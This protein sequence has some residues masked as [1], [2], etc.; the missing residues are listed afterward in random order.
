MGQVSGDDDHIARAEDHLLF[1]ILP[2]PKMHLAGDHLCNLLIDMGVEGN[3][4]P[5]FQED[6][7]HRHVRPGDDLTFH[8]GVHL[9]PF[10]GVPVEPIDSHC[11]GWSLQSERISVETH[12]GMTA[13]GNPTSNVYEGAIDAIVIGAGVVGLA[14]AKALAETGREVIVLERHDAFGMETSSRNSEVI[15]AGIYYRPG[16]VRARLCHPGK[17]KLFEYARRKNVPHLKCGK[18]IVAQNEGEETQL[19]ALRETAARNGVVD[20][21]L[22]SGKKAEALEPGLRASAALLSPSTGI[23]DSHQLMLALLGD[24]EAAGGALAFG[25]PVMGGA[26]EQGRLIIE[27]GGESPARLSAK[28]VVNCAGH[29]AG[30]VAAMI[31]GL[32]PAYTPKIRPATGRYFTYLGRAPFSRLIYPL[33]TADSQG[34]HY[35]RDLGGQAKLGPDIT[36]DKPLGDYSVEAHLRDQFAA[37]GKRFWPDLDPEKLTPGYAGQRPKASGPG[38]EGDFLILG[39]QSYGTPG[40]IGLYAI[41]SPGLTAC[42]AIADEVLT[43][44]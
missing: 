29:S 11:H 3:H 41:E 33:H 39:P 18:L 21:Q 38:E 30:R 24:L 12:F 9:F 31:K 20:L 22:I 40:Y 26:V 14:V 25:A 8:M 42:L 4:K 32:T 35:T 13:H 17:V 16:G 27:T 10:E 23:I 2:E 7:R 44:V 1:F 37:A 36:W 28:L 34:I 5:I 15:H 43:L 6:L 19:K